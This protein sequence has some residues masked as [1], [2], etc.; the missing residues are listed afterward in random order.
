MKNNILII[1][2]IVSLTSM[3]QEFEILKVEHYQNKTAQNNWPNVVFYSVFLQSFYDSNGDGIGDINGL[4]M[5]LDYLK[6]LGVG[7]IWLLPIHPSPTYHKYDVSNYYDIHPDYGTMDDFKLLVKE[8]HKRN[9]K[10]I[11]DLVINHTSDQIEWFQKAMEGDK[12]YKD[13][14]VWSDDE[15]LISKNAHQW[16][17]PKKAI[18]DQF[19]DEKYYGFFWHEMPDLNFDNPDVRKEI[20]DI[21]RFWLEDVGIDGFR[22]DAIRFIYPE[23]ENEKN[24]AWWQEF[25]AAMNEVNPDFYMVG[26]IWGEDTIVAPFLNNAVHAGFNFDVSFKLVESIKEETN[27]GVIEKLIATRELYKQVEPNFYDAVF[28]TNHDQ[29]R[30]LSE[31]DVNDKAGEVAAAIMLTLPGSPFVYYGEEIGMLGVKPDEYI[32]EPFLWDLPWKDSSQ[33]S[34]IEPKYSN[35][36]TVMPLALQKKMKKGM[37]YHYK[38]LIALR[39]NSDALTLGEI[40][41]IE[42]EEKA[43]VAYER[44][45]K[46]EKILLIHNIS[47]ESKIIEIPKE[48]LGMNRLIFSN[49]EKVQRKGLTFLLDKYS[50]II[51]TY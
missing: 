22:L 2:L 19:K 35:H 29:N 44:F 1:L 9:V 32:R 12:K 6:D 21:G 45:Y 33:T 28:L 48:Y 51:L 42:F 50:T 13:Y 34:W 26:E 25:R 3:S 30:V 23:E 7:G 17:E 37:F 49:M 14:Y 47:S 18:T 43:I 24:H 41:N 27:K 31:L 46:S 36:T 15:K 16:H 8:A 38:N 39:N 11:I 20:K 40:K 5:K 10:I 4:R